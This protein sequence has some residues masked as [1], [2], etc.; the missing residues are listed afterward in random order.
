MNDA[1]EPAGVDAS[2]LRERLPNKPEAPQK[3]ESVETAQQ[4]VRA[5]NQQ[6]QAD[7]KE[8]KD[9]KTYGRTLEGTGEYFQCSPKDGVK[10][11]S[12][13]RSDT[14]GRS[15][16]PIKPEPSLLAILQP[17]MLFNTSSA[18]TPHV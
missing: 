13:L 18:D 15:R 4:A 10:R 7:G 1:T 14:L 12:F 11:A 6:E 16:K 2:G 17:T 5:L 9:R 8:E 3:A